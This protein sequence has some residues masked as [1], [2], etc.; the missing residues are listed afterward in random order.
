MPRKT[1]T[2]IRKPMSP[3]A[4]A[5]IAEAV[6]KSAQQKRQEAGLPPDQVMPK[7]PLRQKQLELVK[8][9]DQNFD[10]SLFIPM[11]SGR[12]VDYLFTPEGGLPKATNYIIIGDPGVGKS[13]VGLD[14]L[15]DLNEKGHKCL[16]ISA[17]MTR[18]DLYKY[19]KRYP[20]FGNLD[21][22]F[23]G[24]YSDDNPKLVMEE[25]LQRGYDC[26]LIDSFAEVQDSVK[27]SCRM[28]QNSAEKWLVDLMAK[29][30]MAE[31][32]P[33]T[34]TTFLC[35]QQVTKGG[36]FLG[37]NK[38][39]HNTTGMLELRYDEDMPGASYLSFSKNRRGSCNV[40]M[41]FSIS[42]GGEVSY[43]DQT[44]QALPESDPLAQLAK[45]DNP[46]SV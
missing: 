24:E 23:L 25:I 9:K 40:R 28:T 8:M 16:Y 38:L 18:I 11:S 21:I 31:N 36:V 15:S 44:G 6:K 17:E 26:V 46:F 41:Y 22:L 20:K 45:V 29:H 12:E 30:N 42:Q 2:G 33:K 3:E 39:K 7:G 35:I 1:S 5:K 10:P 4:R 13:T 32:T 27:E 37:S 14:I 43:M 19:V 34:H